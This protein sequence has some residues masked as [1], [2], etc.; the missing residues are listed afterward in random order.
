MREVAWRRHPN[1][2]RQAVARVPVAKGSKKLG[3]SF[4]NNIIISIVQGADHHLS[5]AILRAKLA[6]VVWQP[7]LELDMFNEM[8]LALNDLAKF[9]KIPMRQPHGV[10]NSFLKERLPASADGC[11]SRKVKLRDGRL[12]SIS[13]IGI[14]RVESQIFQ[15]E[16]LNIPGQF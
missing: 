1:L 7:D 9:V 13:S 8:P 12:A 11:V 3:E 2:Q 15:D 5:W 6:V 10:V 4:A 14:A 16:Q